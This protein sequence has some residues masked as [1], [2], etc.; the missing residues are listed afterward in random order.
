MD[1]LNII[2]A[3]IVG[4]GIPT[5]I[6]AFVHIGRKLQIL[7]TLD[8]NF[9]D[10]QTDCKSFSKDIIL[11]KREVFGSGF[12]PLKLKDKYKKVLLESDIDEQIK[13]K[14]QAII[15]LIQNKNPPTPLDSQTIIDDNIEEIMSWLNLTNLKNKMY[16]AGLSAGGEK[17]LI[18]L[19]LYEIIIPKLTFK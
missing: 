3:I 18:T 2:N 10:I 13:T 16:E 11:L 15:D 19:Y 12:S 1:I 7:D 6:C 14:E 8:A 9:K 5:I 17:Y 4:I